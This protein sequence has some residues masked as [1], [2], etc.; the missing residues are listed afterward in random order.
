MSD[1]AQTRAERRDLARWLQEELIEAIN[2]RHMEEEAFNA[3]VTA[4]HQIMDR[5]V[6]VDSPQHRVLCRAIL[7]AAE[8]ALHFWIESNPCHH[9]DVLADQI[10]HVHS[11]YGC[12]ECTPWLGR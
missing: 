12:E 10:I 2:E 5:L 7:H 9:E 3:A 6:A 11:C 4:A 8:L 1:R